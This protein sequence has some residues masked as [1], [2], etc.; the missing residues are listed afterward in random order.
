[1]RAHHP[2][3]PYTEVGEALTAIVDS[4][5][6]A[7]VKACL[8]FITLT[9][10]RS[11]E[12]RLARWQEIDL[13][14]REWRIPAERMKM[15]VEH[16]VP[17]SGPAVAILEAL[18]PKEDGYV[19]P[20]SR[21]GKPIVSATLPGALTRLYGKRATVHGFRSSFRTWAAERTSYTRD[22]CE[23]ALAHKVGSD[24]E[25]SY[26]RTDLFERRRGLMDAW[27]AY[28]TGDTG[29]VVQIHAAS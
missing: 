25:R 9:A 2:A 11:N 1:M 26:A 5:A 10:V 16:R 7:A 27:A 19:F 4:S 14:A 20:G 23:M 17:L 15:G 21:P 3:L 22:V 28:L 29:K 13:E 8:Q 24:V 6:G 12:A 18:G